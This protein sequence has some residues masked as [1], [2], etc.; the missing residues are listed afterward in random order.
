MELKNYQKTVMHDLADYMD[1]VN[2][3]PDLFRAWD[4]YWS[5]KDIAVGDHGVPGYNNSI[6]RVPHVCMKV[7]T[8]GGKTFMACA[9]LK[10]IF[11][12][13]PLLKA[14]VVVWLVPSN[15]IL[16]Q[17]ISNL[18]NPNHPYRVR[19]DRDFQG[20]VEVLT[21]EE[22]LS[23][24]NFSPDTVRDELTV[25][26][27]S[28]DSLRIDSRNKDIRKVYQENGN[29][30]RF[31]E[32]Y[33]NKE[34][35]LPNTPD[36][37]L[38]QVLRQ[39]SPVTI[40]DE[41]HNASSDLS[42]EMLNHLNPSF[43]LDLTAT[44]R[45][46]SNVISYVDARELKKEHMVKLP[47]IV[48]NRYSKDEV[49]GDAIRLRNFLEEKARK[50]EENGAPYIRPIVLFQAQPKITSDSDTF[51][52][53]K[54]ILVDL[55]VPENQIAIKTSK[56]DDL[57]DR[58]LHSRDCPVRY[59][60]TVNALKEGWDCPFAYILASLANK[61]SQ[62]DVEQILGRV[63]RQ[64]YAKRQNDSVLNISYVLTC[65]AD[66][67]ST[68]D[69]VVKGLN[70]AGF[71][72]KDYR[73]GSM[74]G[75]E[76]P[77]DEKVPTSIFDTPAQVPEKNSVAMEDTST[78]DTAQDDLSDIHTDAISRS[79]QTPSSMTIQETGTEMENP[80]DP[81]T[82]MVNHAEER[83]KEY[84]HDAK[85]AEES[86]LKGGE[87]G[88][89]LHQYKMKSEFQDEMQTIKLPQFAIVTGK[90][91]FSGADKTAVT[92]DTFLKGFSL[93]HEDAH[94][95]FSN[96]PD[97]M[98]TVDLSETGEAVPQYKMTNR[99]VRAAFRESLEAMPNEQK[100]QA[101]INSISSAIS[102]YDN[103][104]DEE[105]RQYLKRVFEGL[106][107]NEIDQALQSIN[108]Y[109]RAVEEKIRNLQNE[110]RK[111]TFSRKAEAD[112]SVS[113]LY[114]FPKVITPAKAVSS[115]P[116]S[117]YEAESNDMNNFEWTMA[118]AM[119]QMDNVKWWHRNIERKG[120]FI[121]GF[122]NHYPDFIVMTKAGRIL[123][124][125]TKGD[126]LLNDDSRDK[127]LLGRKWASMAGIS[128][129]YFMVFESIDPNLDGAFAKEDFLNLL[130]KL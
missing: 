120:F 41:S 12:R 70:G 99:Y 75:M 2:E 97:N 42:I 30:Y 105:V 85:E 7:P 117:L 107:E 5:R 43:V 87:L 55:H 103:V 102:R 68:L 19:L 109:G 119:A 92:K 10:M 66:F 95:A 89:M 58:N 57:K 104:K 128:Y 17:T 49:I 101:C 40:V 20:K 48:Y 81:L 82:S 84:I 80:S 24:Q 112:L 8:G 6:K 11:E 34:M 50:E 54:K 114:S 32:E 28:Y 71:S 125:E 53:I 33:Q 65:S 124:V 110:Y 36:T 26:V 4:L 27:L 90:S 9:S 38:I 14:R 62:V 74:A 122:I 118:N 116:K 91:L 96:T 67:R 113:P 60:I 78:E 100:L 18:S 45:S 88:D 130:K 47:V 123:M 69:S 16:T 25:C 106:T 126:Q 98:Y 13:M 29:L 115:I 86:G 111:K 73:I 56:V 31:A 35:L 23:G 94:V 37:A 46:N 59:I 121:N 76:N 39:L 77:A 63:L 93:E 15:S 3:A 72:S 44:P 51:E 64:P 61:T 83:E 129:R 22:L 21:K 127:L 79:L 52:K 108:A 1:A